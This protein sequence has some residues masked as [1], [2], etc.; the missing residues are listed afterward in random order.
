VALELIDKQDNFEI[1]RDQIAAILKLETINQVQLATN[2][3]KPNPEDWKLRVF[4]E[5]SNPWEQFLNTVKDENFD[6]S[7]II[8]VW[9]NDTSYDKKKSN[10][11]ERQNGEG[12]FNIDCIGY[13]EA[14]DVDGGGHIAGDESASLEA[15]RALKFVR[16]IMMAAEN[17]YLKMRGV[18]WGR[19]PQSQTAFQPPI[20]DKQMQQ[21]MGARLVLKVSFNEFS[22]QVVGEPIELIS[23]KTYRSETGEILIN[24]DY[25]YTTP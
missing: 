21:I 13:G 19:W 2:A 4:S 5:R 18:V 6:K 8:N 16:N 22:P 7:P 17:T 25:D 24:A 11:V 12:T 9:Y 1:I 14:K 15:Q 23:T 10:V 3:G 20:S